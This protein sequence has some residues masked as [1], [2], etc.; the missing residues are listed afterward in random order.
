[1]PPVDHAIAEI[2]Q[3]L[4]VRDQEIHGHEVRD[5]EVRAKILARL[6]NRAPNDNGVKHAAD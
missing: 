4:A 5:H 1:M 6:R 2:E 3:A